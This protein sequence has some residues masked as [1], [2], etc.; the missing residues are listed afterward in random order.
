[1][2][3]LFGD[4]VFIAVGAIVLW[5]AEPIARRIFEANRRYAAPSEGKPYRGRWL[6][7]DQQ[8]LRRNVWIYRLIGIFMIAM[9]TW[10][11]LTSRH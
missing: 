1:M 10:W 4:V 5:K 11:G 2:Q 6:R 8:M 9:G 3:D 7:F